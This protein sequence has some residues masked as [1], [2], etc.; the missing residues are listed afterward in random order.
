MMSVG[1]QELRHLGG[2]NTRFKPGGLTVHLRDNPTRR[3]KR[4]TGKSVVREIGA[5]QLGRALS[6][7]VFQAF[8]TSTSANAVHRSNTASLPLFDAF[9]YVAPF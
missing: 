6:L 2:G 1:N 4:K 5:A 7:V 9:F 8:E 3:R